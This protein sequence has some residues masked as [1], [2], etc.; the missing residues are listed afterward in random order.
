MTELRITCIKKN[1]SNTKHEYITHVG[2]SGDIYTKETI[3]NAI[4]EKKFTF[5]VQDQKTGIRS[6][7]GV[8]TPDYGAPYLRT[9]AD[10][11]WNDNLLALMECY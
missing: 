5:F 2:I 9:Y 8:V 3:I 7:V 10:G 4:K 6:E 11:Y 1:S